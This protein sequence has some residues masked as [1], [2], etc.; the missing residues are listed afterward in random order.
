LTDSTEPTVLV[1]DDQEDVADTHA[2]ML[3]DRFAV[4]TA[5]SGEEALAAVDEAVDVAVLDRQMPDLNGV[6]V[7]EKIRDR[8]LDCRIMLFTG[9][10]PD[11][12]I[13]ELE[14]DDY[15]TKP[16]SQADLQESVEEVL[17]L[18]EYDASMADFF[19]LSNKREVLLEEGTAGG[20]DE[21]TQLGERIA[22]KAAE[23]L[24]KN[25]EVLETIVQSSPAAIVT[26]DPD[27]HVDLWNPS[28]E[29][30]FGWTAGEVLGEDP[31]IFPADT[32]GKLETIRNRLFTDAI[33]TD[34]DIECVRKTGAPLDVSLS[35]APLHDSDGSMD[36]MVFVMMDIT[37]R[38]QREQRI[39]VL[40]RVL[41][42]NLRNE[43]TVV[44]G[45]AEVLKGSVADEHRARIENIIETSE[46]LVDMSETAREIEETLGTDADGV[47]R[48]DIETVIRENVEKAR[49]EYPGAE[50][51]VDVETTNTAVIASDGMGRAVWNLL[52]NAIEHNERE[53]PTVSVT[54]A[55]GATED[56]P[57]TTITV[58]DDGT[59]IPAD[60]I[61]VIQEGAQDKLHHGSG[62]GLWL[63]NWVVDR[64]GGDLAFEINGTGGTTAT[65]TLKQATSE[66][67]SGG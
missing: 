7:A 9:V 49:D 3:E 54:V 17:E 57:T 12:D 16:A 21:L 20:T 33:V 53:T 52:E 43:L 2:R 48:R 14:I 29:E 46:R 35:A 36:G 4:R 64:S 67:S 61:E 24:Q 59:G 56:Q 19:A 18:A 10:E 32:R 51:T 25:R 11:V 27:G 65:V 5:Y 15:L 58:T 55:D 31:P 6:E 47:E 62:L 37:E 8:G 39:S 38:K 13:I 60:E 45:Q 23:G 28:A 41:R 1:V 26:L 30:L 44:I 50:L 34:M 40:G 22:Q 42:H 66:T 63:V